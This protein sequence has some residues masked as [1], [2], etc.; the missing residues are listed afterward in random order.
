MLT[1]STY[2]KSQDSLFMVQLRVIPSYL[3]YEI[4]K[5]PFQVLKTFR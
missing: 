4:S 1:E 5:K 3:P 2:R